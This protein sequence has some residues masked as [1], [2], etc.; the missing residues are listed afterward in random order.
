M[1]R[2]IGY[3][4]TIW[5][6]QGSEFISR[7]MDLWVFQRRV[8]LDFSGPG[9]PSDEAFNGRSWAKCLNSQSRGP[10]RSARMCS[11]HLAQP[12]GLL[13]QVLDPYPRP[14]H[15]VIDPFERLF[16]TIDVSITD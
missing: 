8:T 16:Q 13:D 2:R 6:D 5:V 9:K 15:G 14:G 4:S 7:D 11:L 1:C 12:I 10:H 3:P